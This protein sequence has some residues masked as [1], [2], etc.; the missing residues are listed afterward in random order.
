M[1][2]QE[3]VNFLEEPSVRAFITQSHRRRFDSKQTLIHSGDTPQCLYL[4]LEGSVSILAENE[5]GREMV[6]AYCH[7]GE[8]FGEMCLF[9]HL[10]SRSAL[11]RTRSETWVAEMGFAPFKAFSKSN[12]EIMTVLAGQLALRLRD[13]SRRLADLNFLDVSGRIARILLDL[14]QQPDAEQHPRGQSVKLSRQE[15]ARIAGCSREMA[16]RVMKALEDDG[17]IESSGRTVLILQPAR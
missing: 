2:M 12:P 5:Q 7:P 1:S 6:L 10:E 9:P 4:L 17:L 8:F 11:V 15:L 3:K 16:G 14:A 13:T